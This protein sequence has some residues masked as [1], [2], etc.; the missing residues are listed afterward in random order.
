M[1]RKNPNYLKHKQCVDCDKLITD[2]AIRCRSCAVKY[3]YKVTDLHR[4]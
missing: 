1:S 3:L 4:G 2:Y